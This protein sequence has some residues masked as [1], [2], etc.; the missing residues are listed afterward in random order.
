[1]HNKPIAVGLAKKREYTAFSSSTCARTAQRQRNEAIGLRAS[2]SSSS[3]PP[4]TFVI[5]LSTS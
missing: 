2:L 1:M 4:H 5:E 3:A